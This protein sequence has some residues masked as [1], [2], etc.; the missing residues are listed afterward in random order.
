MFLTLYFVVLYCEIPLFRFNSY[1]QI[2]RDG[3]DPDRMVVEFTITFVINA[4]HH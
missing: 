1:S 4:Y 3:R 2:Y